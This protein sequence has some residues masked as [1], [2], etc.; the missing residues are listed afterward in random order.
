MFYVQVIIV[1]ST[2]NYCYYYKEDFHSFYE[3]I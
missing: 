1:L 3:A 2:G